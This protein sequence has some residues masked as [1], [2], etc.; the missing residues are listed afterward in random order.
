LDVVL[1]GLLE[2]ACIGDL[3]MKASAPKV[4][5]QRRSPRGELQKRRE[6]VEE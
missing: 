4:E 1:L 6:P 3:W 2:L 5:L